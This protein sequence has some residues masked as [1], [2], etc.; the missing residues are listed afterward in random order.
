VLVSRLVE[1]SAREP[2]T[3]YLQLDIDQIQATIEQLCRRIETRFPGSGLAG[4]GR[5]VQQ[6]A[7]RTRERT[8]WFTR[9]ILPLRAAVGALVA[10]IAAGF[11]GTL[12]Q[13]RLPDEPFVLFDFVQALE[14]GINDVVLVGAGVFFLV[15]ME[16][17]IKRRRALEAINE[18]RAIAHIIDMHQLTKDPEWILHRGRETGV[19]P[20]RRL[21][22]FELSRYLDYCSEMLSL[23]GKLAALYIQDSGDSVA[24]AAVNEVEDLTTGLSRKIWQ[25]LMI[26]HSVHGV[27]APTGAAGDGDERSKTMGSRKEARFHRWED[28]P[29]EKLNDLLERRLVTGERMMLAHVYLKKGCVVPRHFHENEQLTYVL[30][31]ALH[32]WLGENG[33]REQVVRAGEVLVI[34]SNLPHKAEALEDTLD[35]DIFAPP[36]QDWLDGTDAYLRQK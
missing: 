13:M 2:R 8:A 31:G 23:T 20:P 17:R 5:E 34:P 6:I 33:E 27:T 32:F 18:L 21:E 24:L 15:T 22:P 36:R 9:P 30:E 3:S 4:V 12:F 29:K 35:V 16:G 19:L 1:E 11:V 26:L 14:S 7:A 28:L 25:K 10:L